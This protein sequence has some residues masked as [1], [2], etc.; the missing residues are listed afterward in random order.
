MVRDLKDGPSAHKLAFRVDEAVAAS[1]L[2]RTTLYD[3]IK[4]GRLRAVKVAGRRLI[5]REDL[6][7]FLRSHMVA[8]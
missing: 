5:M 6:E 8:L 3:E 7:A 4:A 2:G 1:G